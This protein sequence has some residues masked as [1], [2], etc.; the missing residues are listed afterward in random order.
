M[1]QI[2]PNNQRSGGRRNAGRGAGGWFIGL[3]LGNCFGGPSGLRPGAG[4]G[5]ENLWQRLGSNRAA[6]D[7]Q[8]PGQGNHR[9]VLYPQRTLHPGDRIQ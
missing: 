8:Y 9:Q 4:G 3:G 7:L 2:L 6:F 5:S 1:G